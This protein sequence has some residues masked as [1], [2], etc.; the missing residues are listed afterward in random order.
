[1]SNK[2]THTTAM[3]INNAKCMK[4]ILILLLSIICLQL[5]YAQNG[6]PI[7]AGARGA[8]MGGTGL[9][10]Y[11]V[12]AAFLNQAG[13]AN[14]EYPMAIAVAERRFLNSPIQ[15]LGGAIAY[16]TDFGT[17]GL[18]LQNFGIAEF[19]EQKVGLAYARKLLDNFRLGIQFDFLNTQI[20]DYGSKGILTF[21]IGLQIDLLPDLQLGLHA[22]S[23]M[24]VE[25]IEGEL[26]PTIYSVG[27]AY[28]ASEKVTVNAELMKDIDYP[29]R[30]RA[31]VE[32]Q[33]LEQFYFR[34]G[35]ASA[36]TLVT[37]GVGIALEKG[38][39]IDIA[40]TYHQFLGI[41]PSIAILYNFRN[42]SK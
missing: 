7:V 27:V 40:S 5:N 25:L 16:P 41:S 14:V 20:Q 10:F 24:Q 38:L 28:L 21:E 29:V 33:M 18:T 17:F 15:S 30:F 12:N 37:L 42:Y 35:M 26:I 39:T 13:L 19:N 31:G 22:Y 4:T 2:Q 6:A 1:M 3:N 9:N 8:G 34:V 11:D 36:P 23:P 32:Y